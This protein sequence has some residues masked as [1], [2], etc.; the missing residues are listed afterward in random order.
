MIIAHIYHLAPMLLLEIH[1][2]RIRWR[3]DAVPKQGID[4]NDI[5][6]EQQGKPVSGLDLE[7]R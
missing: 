7:K 4:F 3:S 1:G 2:V 6:R 5:E